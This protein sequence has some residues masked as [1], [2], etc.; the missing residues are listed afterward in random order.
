[1]CLFHT[2]I[3]TEFTGMAKNM[4]LTISNLALPDSFTLNAKDS[5]SPLDCSCNV[6]KAWCGLFAFLFS[7]VVKMIL[8]VSK[9]PK[10]R[11]VVR[12]EDEEN[13]KDPYCQMTSFEL[14]CLLA[15]LTYC[16]LEPA[17]TPAPLPWTDTVAS[18]KLQA[19]LATAQVA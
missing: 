2:M 18:S 5:S 17:P 6:R 10:D 7:V 16:S 12:G 4:S 11:A 13:L 14:E 3:K 1:M 8:S 19:D 9:D 15:E